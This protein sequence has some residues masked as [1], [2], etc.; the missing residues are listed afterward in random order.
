MKRYFKPINKA[1]TSGGNLLHDDSTTSEPGNKPSVC[2]VLNLD[3]TVV[4]PGLRKPIYE[5]DVGIRDQVRRKFLL[6]G[7]C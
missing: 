3:D 6:M 7:P 2:V 1:V 4:D 5:Y